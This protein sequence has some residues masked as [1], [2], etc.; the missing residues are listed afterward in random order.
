ML[1]K[2]DFKPT[3]WKLK[4]IC[5]D[6]PKY[7]QILQPKVIIRES[8]IFVKS[9]ATSHLWKFIPDISQIFNLRN[10]LPATGSLLKVLY[11]PQKHH[12]KAFRSQ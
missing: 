8:Y 4:Q 1:Q 11:D 12:L 10:L 2:M 7:Y 3:W 9:I 6:I 5:L